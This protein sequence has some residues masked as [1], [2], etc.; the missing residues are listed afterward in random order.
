[1]ATEGQ[2]DGANAVDRINE[3][4]GRHPRKRALHAKGIWLRGTFRATPEAAALSRA[5]HLQ[6]EE[7]PVLARLSNGDGHP[8]SPDF[9][10]NIRGLAVKFE[11]PGG[12]AADL[13]SQSAPHFVNRTPE[14]FLDLLKAQTGRT[15]VIKLPLFFARTPRAWRS[16]PENTNALRPIEGFDRCRFYSIHAFGWVAA[17][18]S[19]THVRCD[20]VPVLGEK[21]IGL[22]DARSRGR[23]YL[24]ESLPDALPARWSLDAQIA[25]P[26]DEVDDP[27]ERWPS[28]RRRIDA[29]TL[30]LTEIIGDPEAGG[31]II[32]F[33]AV[34][35]TDGI[36]LTDDPVLNFR[37][38]AYSESAGRRAADP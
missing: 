25:E 32:V 5:H 6:A 17:D 31:D 21:R 19:K 15:A 16:L 30:E 27:S 20:W 2:L 1:M 36:E 12:E 22:R 38:K 23:D 3:S 35:V 26:E 33:D 9:L 8:N 29:G 37:P 13:V 14:G 18:G 10:P 4:F 34:R 11:L 28:S 24:F 7:V